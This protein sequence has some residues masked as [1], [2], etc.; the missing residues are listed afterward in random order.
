MD[1]RRADAQQEAGTPIFLDDERGPDLTGTIAVLGHRALSSTT[2]PALA[3]GMLRRYA[4]E[5]G[6][7]D[8]VSACDEVS[9]LLEQ[10]V[11]TLRRQVMT[12][13]MS[14]AQA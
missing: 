4:L 13:V 6:D 9:A 11:V 7:R 10:V 1:G 14:P 3:I 5:S 2:S 12:T 8:L